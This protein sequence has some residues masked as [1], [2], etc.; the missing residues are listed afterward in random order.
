VQSP[1][2]PP[3]TPKQKNVK[4]QCRYCD[5]VFNQPDAR[6][7]HETV[8]RF[9]DCGYC[10]KNFK[11]QELLKEHTRIHTEQTKFLC[12][13]PTCNEIF[14]DRRSLREHRLD[15]HDPEEFIC[16]VEE[17]GKIFPSARALKNHKN[18]KHNSSS[19]SYIDCD[20]CL[21][22]FSSDKLNEHLKLHI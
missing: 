8:H 6:D 19:D 5:R 9:F 7:R 22:K 21:Q 11:T 4:H 12:P 18:H 13:H 14:Q 20:I 17:C 2:T 3:V 16:E 1:P 10:S 15:D